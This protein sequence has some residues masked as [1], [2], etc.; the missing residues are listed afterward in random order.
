MPK[1]PCG[2]AR[3]LM[4]LS[5][6][7]VVAFAGSGDRLL[8]ELSRAGVKL[9]QEDTDRRKRIQTL[10]TITPFAAHL[11]SLFRGQSTPAPTSAVLAPTTV[12]RPHPASAP[13]PSAGSGGHEAY[14]DPEWVRDAAASIARSEAE[15]AKWQA[16]EDRFAQENGFARKVNSMTLGSYAKAQSGNF[17]VPSFSDLSEAATYLEHLVG[18][19]RS[20]ASTIASALVEANSLTKPEVQAHYGPVRTGQLQAMYADHQKAAEMDL[21]VL[22]AVISRT[23]GTAGRIY[24][25]SGSGVVFR[26]MTFAW[27][28]MDF[29]RM[30][31]VGELTLLS[32]EGQPI[33]LNARV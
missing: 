12:V 28:G 5:T 7:F 20:N 14:K 31:T 26:E 32:P 17:G 23:F 22:N 33:R 29:A 27:N 18:S 4:F 2:D 11:P 10:V 25:Q 16:N 19:M 24:D 30:S 1:A 3:G 6:G 15:M 13:S 9:T 8:T 21:F